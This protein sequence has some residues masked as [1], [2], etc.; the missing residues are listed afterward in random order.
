LDIDLNFISDPVYADMKWNID[1][2]QVLY[3][4]KALKNGQVIIETLR[5]MIEKSDVPDTFLYMAMVESKFL[6]TAKSSKSAAGLWQLMPKTAKHLKLTINRKIDERLD[7]IRST[8]VAIKYLQYLHTRF[9]KWYLVAFAYNCGETR[10]AKAIEKSGSDDIFTL[11]D[12][13]QGYLPKETRSY[14]RK[15]IV[16]S[17]I[18]HSDVMLQEAQLISSES[19]DVKL[20]TLKVKEGTSLRK[21]ASDYK[22]PVKTLKKYNAHILKGVTPKGTKKYCIYIPED[23]V[24]NA[25]SICSNNKNI[26]TYTVKA[27]D[28][29]FLISKRFNN[30]ISAIK[31]LN[32]D[33][34]KKLKIGKKIALIGEQNAS[35]K[36]KDIKFKPKKITDV[37]ITKLSISD[38]GIKEKSHIIAKEK[39]EEKKREKLPTKK[40]AVKDNNK[41]KTT[42]IPKHKPH[43]KSKKEETFTYKVQ[44]GEELFDIS[45][46]FNNKISTLEQL[47]GKL[48][49][50]LK[51][52]RI[53][54]IKR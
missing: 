23:K 38:K 33:L 51:E 6:T 37:E 5:K 16:A 19:G 15:L 8:E 34:P 49:K 3:F 32:E 1:K 52:G 48:P 4:A 35:L 31:E 42:K 12:S 36:V 24:N 30:K 41:T 50:R 18:A 2:T 7:P 27:G 53:L 45:K 46:K 20:K 26:F 25:K 43:K 9:H 44:K 21:V 17:L 28:T 13:E 39:K 14:I 11:L 47:N 22:I 10:L 29:L 54:I 40:V